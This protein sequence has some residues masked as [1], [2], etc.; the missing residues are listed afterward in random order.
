MTDHIFWMQ[1][2]A[3]TDKAFFAALGNRIARYR[4]EL[5]LTQTQLAQSL[6]IAQQTLAHYEAARLRVPASMLPTLAEIFGL[7]VDELLGHKTGTAKRG[8]TSK[9][10][11]QIEQ[12]GRLPKAK[13]R[14][15]SEMLE[16]VIKQ[17]S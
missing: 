9:L 5:G 15:V 8:P 6:G 16:T 4:K 14:F 7:S 17:A 13:Q 10:Q 11:R 2:M 1:V 12:I 3:S